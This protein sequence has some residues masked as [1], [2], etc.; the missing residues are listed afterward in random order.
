[1]CN[2]LVLHSPARGELL[3][4]LEPSQPL[5][6]RGPDEPL[7]EA[8]VVPLVPVPTPACAYIAATSDLQK[9][10]A[11]MALLTAFS[12]PPRKKML[13]LPRGSRGPLG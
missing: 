7:S 10:K 13:T 11:N 4:R 1:M 5:L 3:Q 6:S 8:V 9:H 12:P 2:S